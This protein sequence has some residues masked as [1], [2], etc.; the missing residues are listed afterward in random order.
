VDAKDLGMD[1]GEAE[2]FSIFEQS[3]LLQFCT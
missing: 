1:D 2:H 3:F